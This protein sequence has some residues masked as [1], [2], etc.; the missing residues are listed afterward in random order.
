MVSLM[1]VSCI[2]LSRVLW[3]KV[4]KETLPWGYE[5]TTGLCGGLGI[6]MGSL[7]SHLKALIDMGQQIICGIVQIGFL[8]QII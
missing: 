7:W 6:G 1:L 4:M 3:D 2:E 8:L 5:T